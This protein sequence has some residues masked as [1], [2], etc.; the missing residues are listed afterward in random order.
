MLKPGYRSFNLLFPCQEISDE[1]VMEALDF[2]DFD[3]KF[4][5]KANEAS[6]D[7]VAKKEQGKCGT[8]G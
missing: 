8:V 3:K 2:A 7:L 6:E 1:E 5:L 4:E